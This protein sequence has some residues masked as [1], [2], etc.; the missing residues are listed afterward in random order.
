MRSGGGRTPLLSPLHVRFPFGR[1]RFARNRTMGT[2]HAGTSVD[3]NR[4]R[5]VGNL[6]MTRSG[7]VR[8]SFLF[9]TGPR[10]RLF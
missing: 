2:I 7:R 10:V 5:D 3:R 8:T 6:A 9:V 4:T 1:P